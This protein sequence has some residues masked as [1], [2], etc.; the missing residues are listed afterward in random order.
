MSNLQKFNWKEE[1]GIK[2]D[3]FEGLFYQSVPNHLLSNPLIQKDIWH[4]VD[5][6]GLEVSE[7]QKILMFNFTLINPFWFKLLTK[8]YLLTRINLKLS[9]SYLKNDIIYFRKFSNFLKNYYLI[10]PQQINNQLFEEFTYWLKLTGVTERTISL[11][12][13]SL[14][15]FFDTCRIEGWL[16]INTYWFKGRKTQSTASNDNI[17]YLP[18]VIWNQLEESL[19]YFPEPM[20]R[21]ILIIRTLGLRIGELLNLPLDCLKKRGKQWHLRLKETERIKN[22]G[23]LNLINFAKQ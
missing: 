1:L 16:E 22:Y 5:D 21:K 18:E 4:T 19:H 15:N 8:L 12:Y 13:T 23:I 7:H 10:S 2:L 9:V 3:N 17:E 14:Q 6:L 20:Q 11:H